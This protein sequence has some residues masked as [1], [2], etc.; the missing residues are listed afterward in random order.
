LRKKIK[1]NVVLI[2]K[3][4]WGINYSSKHNAVFNAHTINNDVFRE[5]YPMSILEAAGLAVGLP[6]G[7]QGSS[8]VGHLN[9]GAG[10]IVA[11]E[12]KRVNEAMANG[13]F[14][15]NINFQH[16]ISNCRI[17]NSAIHLMGLVQDEGVHAHQD[18]LFAL[19]KYLKQQRIKKVCIHFFSDGR[20][21]P[22]RSANKFLKLLNE[23][24]SE[25]K[26]GKVCTLMGRYYAMDRGENWAL[27]TEAYDALTR[28]KGIQVNSPEEAIEKAYNKRTRNGTEMFDEYI[29]PSVIGNFAGIKDSD[30]VIFFNYRQDR[31][32]QLTK[33][34]VE[35]QYP[36][37]RWK[38]LNIVFCGFTKYYDT[39]PHYVLEPIS[40]AKGMKNI[41]G[42]V[43]SKHNLLQLRISETQ[44][45][46]HITSF[47]NGKR[48]KPFPGE[49]RIEIKSLYDPATYAKHPQMNAFELSEAVI[50]QIKLNKFHV[51]VLNYANCDMV[52]HTGDYKAAIKA[53]EVV[54]KCVGRVVKTILSVKGVALVTADHGNVEEMI[55]YKTMEPKTSHT[56]NPVEF[57]YIADDSINI[58][59]KSKG[60]LSDIAPTILFLLGINKPPDM[61]A[62]NLIVT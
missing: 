11:Q 7:Y 18:H 44:K 27:T 8:E 51:I 60:I 12:L 47:F 19:M 40:D 6:D 24:I 37:E 15:K 1:K 48:M 46:R 55:D 33:A 52:G 36:G 61:T 58:K 16:V 49:E 2:I 17:N 20:D 42:E 23:K 26:I 53:V 3:D 45:F 5:K 13:T 22:P 59:L 62:E 10:R 14:F 31:A 30:S 57:F 4:G 56:K 28:G 21:T 43:L 54:D 50:H 35:D 41:L 39:F 9:I 29:E 38:K 34:F 25:Y 32:I